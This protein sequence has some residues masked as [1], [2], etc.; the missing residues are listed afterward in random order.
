MGLHRTFSIASFLRLPR[1][2]TGLLVAAVLLTMASADSAHAQ[3]KKKVR[4]FVGDFLLDGVSKA[5]GGGLSPQLCNELAM[6]PTLDIDCEHDLRA[7]AS[8]EGNRVL[9]GDINSPGAANIM[10]RLSTVEYVVRPALYNTKRGLM[11]VVKIGER[12]PGNDTEMA[13]SKVTAKVVRKTGQ[14]K[15][16]PVL[17]HLGN[18]AKEIEAALTSAKV[19]PPKSLEGDGR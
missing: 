1:V 17:N 16:G 19:S 5:Q 15:M 9:I 14:R 8:F 10:K 6:Q 3:A 12:K 2:P 7:L 4:V 13:M 11:L 18:V